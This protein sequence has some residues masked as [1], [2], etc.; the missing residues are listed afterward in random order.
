M[1]HT[2]SIGTSIVPFSKFHKKKQTKKKQAKSTYWFQ[3][4]FLLIYSKSG[5]IMVFSTIFGFLFYT[6]HTDHKPSRR[7]N[8]EIQ[9]SQV[10][11]NT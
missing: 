1:H 6:F 10:L 4:R 2:L 9:E 5:S 11:S 3:T 7:L 8:V